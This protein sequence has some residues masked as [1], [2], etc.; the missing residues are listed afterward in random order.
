M[1][2]IVFIYAYG[3][4]HMY[5]YTHMPV[6]YMHIYVYMCIIIMYAYVCMRVS[7]YAILSMTMLICM[8]ERIRGN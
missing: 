6:L 4:L 8:Y 2:V 7:L 5:M 3:C 1:Y